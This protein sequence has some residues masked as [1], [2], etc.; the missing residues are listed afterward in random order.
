MENYI[1]VLRYITKYFDITKDHKFDKI[2]SHT[3]NIIF[4]EYHYNGDE[5]FYSLIKKFSVR[6]YRS[7]KK[8]KISKIGI[9]LN[10]YSKREDIDK[11][12]REY[13]YF[14]SYKN[15]DKITDYIL[16]LKKRDYNKQIFVLFFNI[17]LDEFDIKIE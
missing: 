14:N 3:M 16:E 6:F 11:I 12:L 5:R 7:N 1:K 13:E 8:I 9:R 2:I 17:Y 15:I 4:C 10:R